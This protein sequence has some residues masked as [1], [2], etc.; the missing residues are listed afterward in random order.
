MPHTKNK[1]RAEERDQ[2]LP[3]SE[4]C[5]DK[6]EMLLGSH[7]SILIYCLKFSE[8]IVQRLTDMD[9]TSPTLH[10]LDGLGVRHAQAFHHLHNATSKLGVQFADP[11]A[12]T[13]M[14]S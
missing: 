7:P 12:K 1:C 9:A 11:T 6:G 5:D 8:L 10:M 4:V 13:C 14:H 3:N 2:M